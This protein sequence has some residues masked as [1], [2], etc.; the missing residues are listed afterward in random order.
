M[1][2]DTDCYSKLEEVHSALDNIDPLASFYHVNSNKFYIC[3]YNKQKLLLELE[4]QSHSI[5]LNT[6]TFEVTIGNVEIAKPIENI[7]CN[8]KD[9]LS[10]LMLPLYVGNE[11]E[12]VAY[13]AMSDTRLE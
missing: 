11:D 3:F 6:N 2:Q 4:L 10:V 1:Y 13:Y 9:Y 7:L 8:S 12:D 5:R